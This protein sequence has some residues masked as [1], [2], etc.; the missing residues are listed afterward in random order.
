MRLLY[1]IAYYFFM[2]SWVLSLP[3]EPFLFMFGVIDKDALNILIITWIFGL[4]FGMP[5]ILFP[6]PRDKD[7]RLM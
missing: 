7:G 4:I 6:P 2:C 1:A 5:Y 3:A